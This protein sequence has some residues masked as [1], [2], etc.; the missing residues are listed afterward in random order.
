M[1][2]LE[3]YKRLQK[4]PSWFQSSSSQGSSVW[5]NFQI[6]SEKKMQRIFLETDPAIALSRSRFLSATKTNIQAE[7]NTEVQQRQLPAGLCPSIRQI[8]HVF[9]LHFL[10]CPHHLVFFLLFSPL[11][12]VWS[13]SSVYSVTAACVRGCLHSMSY[14]H[15][16]FP[17]V[18][19][20]VAAA[21]H[22]ILTLRVVLASLS[23][24]PEVHQ[25]PS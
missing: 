20:H 7:N 9:A 4:C 3:K 19:P 24:N 21:V 18:K 16:H 11:E 10:F 25:W 6:K 14:R 5:R 22:T 1:T 15:W 13:G 2:K 23:R 17:V 12:G 8:A